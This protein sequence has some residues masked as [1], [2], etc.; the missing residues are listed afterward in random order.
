MSSRTWAAVLATVA[1]AGTVVG[2]G[3]ANPVPAAR[4][5][6]DRL[7]PDSGEQVSAYLERATATLTAEEDA[8]PGTQHWALVSLDAPTTPSQLLD[9][10]GD[11]RVSQVLFRVPLDRVQ[12]PMVAIPVAANPTAVQRAPSVAAA[13]LQASVVGHDRQSLL[14]AYSAAQLSA[15]CACV[16]GATVRGSLDQLRALDAAPSVRAV[17]A[18][19]ADAIAGSFAVSPLLPSQ[20]DVVLPGPDN[21]SVPLLG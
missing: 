15:D 12:T 7:G 3:V 14:A 8:D 1:L 2:L 9:D 5:S 4:I 21:G 10:V 19:P 13:R 18:L 16:V 6:T 17:E 20:T 11:V